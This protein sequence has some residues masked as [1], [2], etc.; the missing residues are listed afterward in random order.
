MF[1][2]FAKYIL[3]GKRMGGIEV[4]GRGNDLISL[5]SYSIPKIL[6]VYAWISSQNY[7]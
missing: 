4:T 5:I 2:T 7:P 3:G 1:S 6:T